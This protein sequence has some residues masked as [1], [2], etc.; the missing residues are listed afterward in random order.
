MA[1]EEYVLKPGNEHHGFKNG[2]R[3]VFIGGEPGND[4]I[5][6]TETQA[7]AFRDKVESVAEMAE[8]KKSE[9]E[10]RNLRAKEREIKEALEAKGMS[11]DELLE[12]AKA[13]KV[14]PPK[15]PVVPTPTPTPPAAKTVEPP[16]V[17]K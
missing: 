4:R 11:L 3:H 16:K 13:P 12:Q 14:E 6:L 7:Y 2:N 9:D 8:R 1:T 10:I 15:E 5:E 17:T